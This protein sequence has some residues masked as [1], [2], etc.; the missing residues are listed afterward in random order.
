LTDNFGAEQ[1]RWRSLSPS[2]LRDAPI[3][4]RL[5]ARLSPEDVEAVLAHLDSTERHLVRTAADSATRKRLIL[6]LL[7]H[8]EVQPALERVGISAGAPP[9]NV[10]AMARGPLSLGG[11]I[12]YADLV[13]DGFANAGRQLVAGLAG[14][15]FGCSSGRVVRVLGDVH[16]GISWH[17]CDPN[18]DAV[19]W[20]REHLHGI[21]FDVSP[22]RPPLP[23][24]DGSF[25]FVFA[26][27]IWS[28]FSETAAIDWLSEMKRVIRSG[29]HLLL[30]THGEQSIVHAQAEWQYPIERVRVIEQSLRFEGFWFE[31]VF[32]EAGDWGVKSRDWGM[33]FLT[34]EW[35]LTRTTPDWGAVFFRPGRVERNQDL[36]VLERR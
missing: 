13:V 26:I 31:D 24:D 10:H 18:A 5:Y 8:H 17:G 32:G 34:P 2:L 19:A 16:P 20:G 36:Y 6:S 29:G 30:T 25:D 15:D 23:Y 22:E 7:T 1:A 14:L 33:A 3:T 27:S 21:R 12:Q 11:S 28:H 9:E 4:D 35:L